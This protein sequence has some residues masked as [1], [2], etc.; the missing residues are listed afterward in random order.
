MKLVDL[1][2]KG[3]RDDFAERIGVSRRTLDKFCQRVS[4]PSPEVAKKIIQITGG[5]V[6]YKDLFDHPLRD[7]ER[8]DAERAERYK[9]MLKGASVA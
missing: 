6:S 2:P 9:Q 5:L 1:I 8:E 3:K 4:Y 7:V